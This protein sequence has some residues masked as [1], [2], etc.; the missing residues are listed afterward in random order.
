[1][2]V[3]VR[4]RVLV[5]AD[6]LLAASASP[7]EH[8][9]S[10]VILRMAEI[11]LI[12]AYAPQ[13]VLTEVQRN[14]EAKL[15]QALPAMQM[16]VSRCLTVLPDATASEIAPYRGLA[17]EKDLPILVAAV[18]AKCPWLVTFNG[19]HFRPGHSDVAVATPGEFLMQVRDVLAHLGS[20]AS[21]S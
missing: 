1:M 10:L 3:R 14:L 21:W 17:H 4:P 8:G 9:A 12:D 18:K 7:S 5:D 20:R 6:V 2:L 16:I 13:Q 19:K 11:T 15:P